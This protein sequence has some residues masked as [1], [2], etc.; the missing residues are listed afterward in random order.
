MSIT[1][2]AEAMDVHDATQT[3]SPLSSADLANHRTGDRLVRGAPT[4]HRVAA[5][6]SAVDLVGIT[7]ARI[8]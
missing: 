8:I 4:P 6:H 7:T 1:D 3:L 5:T 2:L